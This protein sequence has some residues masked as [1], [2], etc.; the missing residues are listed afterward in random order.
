MFLTSGWNLK[1][2]WIWWL[3]SVY[4]PH[5][6]VTF[7]T[8]PRSTAS[9]TRPFYDLGLFIIPSHIHKSDS[10]YN[11]KNTINKIIYFSLG[12]VIAVKEWF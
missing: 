11:Y 2:M 5:A 1:L 12:M 7:Q 4:F 8:P 10:S 3:M 9:L 6:S